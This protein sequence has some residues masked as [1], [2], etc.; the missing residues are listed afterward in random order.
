MLRPAIVT[1][2]TAIPTARPTFAV[3]LSV[4]LDLVVTAVW[5]TLA[6]EDVVAIRPGAEADELAVAIVIR[7][8]AD[9]VDWY[10]DGDVLVIIVDR[11]N[12]CRKLVLLVVAPTTCK[13][14]NLHSYQLKRALY[15][16]KNLRPTNSPRLD[17]KLVY[18][19]C[20]NIPGRFAQNLHGDRDSGCC[21]CFDR[22]LKTRH[23]R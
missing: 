17:L 14:L 7:E 18:M 8:D 11:V 1:N 4:K 5:L 22:C 15:L 9:D 10:E 16:R 20:W 3:V 13:K 12:E 2:V 23:R 6:L 21:C 19:L